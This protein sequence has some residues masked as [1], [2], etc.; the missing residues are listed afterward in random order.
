MRDLLVIDAGWG[1]G[2]EGSGKRE[3]K[4][5]WSAADM[6]GAA[7]NGGT[8]AQNVL[9]RLPLLA[10]TSDLA[11]VKGPY[12]QPL[13]L[14]LFFATGRGTAQ[15]QIVG[16]RPTDSATALAALISDAA[17]VNAQIP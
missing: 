17:R 10:A 9:L 6:R 1:M 15:G 4:M 13:A 3:E 11:Q 8:R 7:R 5:Q 2:D 12:L 14:A 16:P